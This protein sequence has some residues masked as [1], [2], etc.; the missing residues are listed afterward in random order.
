M[1]KYIKKQEAQFRKVIETQAILATEIN[2]D[3]LD[4]DNNLNNVQKQQQEQEV[5]QN[6]LRKTMDEE[7][8]SVAQ[9]VKEA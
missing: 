3:V 7:T 1:D 6:S 8:R 5:S 4:T 9:E 2:E